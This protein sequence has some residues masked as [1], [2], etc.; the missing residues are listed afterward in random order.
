MEL[1]ELE[2]HLLTLATLPQT[3]APLISCYLNL[4]L[5]LPA[6]HQ[7]LDERARVVRRT[8]AGQSRQQF[9]EALGRFAVS[10]ARASTT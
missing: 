9:E 7:A 2:R 5:G 4:E 6:Y 10:R 8:L 1:K 3:G